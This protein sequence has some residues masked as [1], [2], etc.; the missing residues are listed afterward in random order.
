MVGTDSGYDIGA[1]GGSVVFPDGLAQ[2]VKISEREVIDN[3]SA[4]D[5]LRYRWYSVR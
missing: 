4:Y 3:E 1:D 5:I 2:R